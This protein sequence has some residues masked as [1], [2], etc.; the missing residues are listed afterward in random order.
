MYSRCVS[1]EVY[2]DIA[3]VKVKPLLRYIRPIKLNRYYH[4]VFKITD[5]GYTYKPNRSNMKVLVGVMVYLY[6][7]MAI[8][9]LAGGTVQEYGGWF[10][11]KIF[12]VVTLIVLLLVGALFWAEHVESNMA[13]KYLELNY[14]F[15]GNE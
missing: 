15:P 4:Y 1:Y 11:V 6:V 7:F 2:D 14:G 12:A 3:I 9:C 8:M 5:A 13:K 10:V